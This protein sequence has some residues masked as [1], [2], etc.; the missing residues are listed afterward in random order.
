MLY[1][2]EFQLVKPNEFLSGCT[3]NTIQLAG[4]QSSTEGRVEVCIN[5]VWGTVCDDSWDSRDARVVCRELGLPYTGTKI[6]CV[7][8]YR[9][10]L[11]HVR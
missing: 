6:L 8:M 3:N 2:E 10:S 9:V 11:T 5:G 1:F 7:C 4:G